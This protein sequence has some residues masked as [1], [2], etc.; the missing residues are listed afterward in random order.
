MSETRPVGNEQTTKCRVRVSDETTAAR[1]VVGGWR[2][3]LRGSG[4]SAGPR[5]PAARS[6]RRLAARTLELGVREFCTRQKL[7][8]SST[9]QW[10]GPGMFW[11]TERYRRGEIDQQPAYAVNPLSTTLIT[12]TGVVQQTGC[13]GGV[14]GSVVTDTPIPGSETQ[15]TRTARPPSP[16]PGRSSHLGAAQGSL[17]GRRTRSWCG[18]PQIMVVPQRYSRRC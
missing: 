14:G 15:G 5:R 16:G 18:C 7:P 12:P 6:V 9:P 4:T 3:R 10:N 8:A 17:R 11:Q 2:R 1:G 13:S